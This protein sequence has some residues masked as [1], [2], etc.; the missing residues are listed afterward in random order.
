MAET[1]FLE[2]TEFLTATE[3]N[4]NCLL[5]KLKILQA[6]NK[7]VWHLNYLLRILII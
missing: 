4:F 3:D 2:N 1:E 6:E 5:D 7:K